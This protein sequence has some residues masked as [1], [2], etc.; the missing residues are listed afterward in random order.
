MIA[1]TS[2][3]ALFS[4]SSALPRAYPTLA[5]V[6]ALLASL[7]G[8]S[9]AMPE[10]PAR[11]ALVYGVSTY[12]ENHSGYP[13][14]G[15]SDDDAYDMK[16]LLTQAGWTVKA[17]IA[18]TDSTTLNESA[19]KKAIMADISSL[20]DFKGLVLFYYSGH[21]IFLDPEQAICP[22]GSIDSNLALREDLMITTTELRSYFTVSNINNVIIILDSCNSGG[23]V[24]DGP[25]TEAIPDLY[26]PNNGGDKILYT[27]FVDSLDSSLRAYFAYKTNG[28][29]VTISAAGALEN[30]WEISNVNGIFT[31]A[32][33]SANATPYS[34]T[35]NDG[36]VSTTELFNYTVAYLNK[37]WNSSGTYPTA[38]W[39]DYHPHLSGTAREYALWAAQ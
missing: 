23:F 38:D 30:S 15:S 20:K 36:Y 16:R 33:L 34:D 18:D 26:G 13:N 31:S 29:I 3:R 21:G 32:I 39:D 22:Y 24:D 28:S 8:F 1:R 4:R 7:A 35:D 25:T 19:S 11:V 37:Y 5:I 6:A 2:R 14:L 27:Y 12:L 10:P 9:C 17:G